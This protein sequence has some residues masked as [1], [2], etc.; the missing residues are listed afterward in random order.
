MR[1]VRQRAVYNL[2]S[3]A[4]PCSYKRLLVKSLKVSLASNLYL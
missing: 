1:A 3:Y 2:L 4:R